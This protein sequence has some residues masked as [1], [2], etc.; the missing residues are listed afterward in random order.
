MKRKNDVVKRKII[1]LSLQWL[2]STE[3]YENKLVKYSEHGLQF[4]PCLH[5]QLC[6]CFYSSSKIISRFLLDIEPPFC[7]L[8][9]PMRS[10]IRQ[11]HVC[12][13]FLWNEKIKFPENLVWTYDK[14]HGGLKTETQTASHCLKCTIFCLICSPPPQASVICSW[15]KFIKTSSLSIN[16]I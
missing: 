6:N 12:A 10:T 2:L 1:L 5:G 11:K 7:W 8:L 4:Y 16:S 9:V 13:G 14:Y 3:I 15:S